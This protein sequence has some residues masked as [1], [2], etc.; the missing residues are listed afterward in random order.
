MEGEADFLVEGEAEEAFRGDK[1]LFDFGKICYYVYISV[2]L[3]I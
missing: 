2:I 3:L 1:N